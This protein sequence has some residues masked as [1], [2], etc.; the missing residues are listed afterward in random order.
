MK[1]F[2][3]QNKCFLTVIWKRLLPLWRNWLAR[4]AVI[5]QLRNRKAGGSR[6]PR[7]EWFASVAIFN[8]EYLKFYER[9]VLKPR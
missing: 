5:K 9:V 7:G 3:P 8:V 6:P 1:S 2:Y 4:S